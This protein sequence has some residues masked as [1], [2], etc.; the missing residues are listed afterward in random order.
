MDYL[1]NPKLNY[2][3]QTMFEVLKEY[4]GKNEQIIERVGSSLVTDSDLKGF[5]EMVAD[6]YQ[7]GYLKAI[8]DHK[9]QLKNMGLEARIK[10]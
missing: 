7:K 4:Y 6:I 3:K 2:L 8:D 10:G 9:E 1:T 5:F